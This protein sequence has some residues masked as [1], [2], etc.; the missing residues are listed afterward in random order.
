MHRHSAI[1]IV[2]ITQLNR[3]WMHPVVCDACM[4]S[5]IDEKD[6]EMNWWTTM[7]TIAKR[8]F[9]QIEN[10]D[11]HIC[12]SIC[13]PVGMATVL[14]HRPK[15]R[16]TRVN[17]AFLSALT[18]NTPSRII[19]FRFELSDWPSARVLLQSKIPIQIRY[20]AYLHVISMCM[21]SRG[22][23]MTAGATLSISNAFL[24][25]SQYC[26][27][28]VPHLGVM[29]YNAIGSSKPIYNYD[30]S[31]YDNISNWYLFC[32]VCALLFEYSWYSTKEASASLL[33]AKKCLSA[34]AA[35]VCCD[36]P[37]AY[38][39][40]THANSLKSIWLSC[41]QTC[42]APAVF[43]RKCHSP[44]LATFFPEVVKKNWLL[45]FISITAF[46]R[47]LSMGP[48]KSN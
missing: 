1:W 8:P 31:S 26:P 27:C 40:V 2:F 18:L 13:S 3:I 5:E 25:A 29:C 46:E 42:A 43:T 10:W 34:G 39:I 19:L 21:S 20:H 41:G 11:L 45:I 12:Q 44:R 32:C 6:I 37:A 47:C 38:N 17:N 14:A 33:H 7:T 4:K 30:D 28:A 23:K 24:N 16:S 22:A 15:A 36:V 48:L 35:S 9:F